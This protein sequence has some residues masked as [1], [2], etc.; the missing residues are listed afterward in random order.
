MGLIQKLLGKSSEGKAEFKA[1]LKHAQEE[2]RI[3]RLIEERAK[4]SNQ[5]EVERYIKEKEEA[6]Y[7]KIL[8]KQRKKNNSEMWS[9]KSNNILKQES[10]IMKNDRPILKEKNIFIDHRND[11]PFTKKGD[12]FFK[13]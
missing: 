7:K 9:S 13:W 11:I 10:N 1:K 5:R 2:D 3:N 4:S 8:D 6:E 12:M